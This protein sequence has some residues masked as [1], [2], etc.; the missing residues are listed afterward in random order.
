MVI[1]S[2]TSVASNFLQIDRL[3][4]LYQLYQEIVIP[5]AVEREIQQLSGYGIDP[6]L[7]L[8]MNWVSVVNPTD[9]AFVEQLSRQLDPGEAEAIVLALELRAD[10]LLID[11]ILGRKIAEE[12]GLTITGTL[13]TLLRAKEKG[14]IYE[15]KPLMD[16]LQTDVGFWI[17]ETLYRYI[18]RLAG[19]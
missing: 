3:D 12:Q 14:F 8:R 13:G 4:L 10:Y 17:H 2:D 9:Q 1:I 15:V 6:N 5:P 18:L 7:F 19:E 11:E 16:Q